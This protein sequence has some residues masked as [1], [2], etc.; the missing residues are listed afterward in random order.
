MEHTLGH[1]AGDGTHLNNESIAEP[2][3]SPP[4]KPRW[5]VFANTAFTVILVASAV[6]TVGDAMFD[7]GSSWLMTSLNPDPLMVSA[8]QIA[9]TLPMFLLTLPA[10]AISD[11]V[12]LRKLL[13]V[14]QVFV[15]IVAFGFAAA[16]WLNWHTPALLLTVTFLL[17]AGGA[18]AAPAWQLI[19]PMI[20]PRREL[21]NAIAV[22][23]ASYNLSRAIGPAIG[24]L[25]IGAFGIDFPFWINALS[26][27]AIVA[28]LV[29]WRP[30]PREVDT[31]PA[32]RL[33]NAVRTGLRYAANNR[34]L[35]STLIRAIVF[36]PFACSYSAL[37]PLIARTQMHS[38]PEVF[39][40]LMGVIGL[41]SIAASF[42]LRKL[43]ERL[44]PDSIAAAGT[45]GMVVALVLF[46]AAREPFVAV[47]ASFIA[48]ASS[49]IVMIT[50]FMSAQ[51][52]LPDW[53]RGRG[54]AVFL[55]VYFGAVTLGSAVWGKLASLE[56]IPAALYVSAGGALLGMVVTWRWKLQTGAAHD[57]A[58]SLHW[59]KPS[60]VYRA[61]NDQGPVLVTV[62]YLIDTKDREPFL[63]LMQEI[64]SQ[65]KRD[66][67]YAW[68]VFEDPTTAGRIVETCLLQSMLEYEY[69]R[70]RVTNADRLIEEQ[71]HRFQKEPQKVSFLVAAKRIRRPWRKL[72]SPRGAEITESE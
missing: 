67:V 38:G 52:A 30:P 25:S 17:G 28:A 2:N 34:D 29:W 6:S 72:H 58:P 44:G 12:D 20:V 14:V 21:A 4:A 22:N 64:G 51:V 70:K 49:I 55:T 24:G 27:L 45:I 26:F 9:I 62:E 15:A 57:L 61:E 7:T 46:A 56:G 47:A 63:A 10:G 42:G 16:I 35:D 37:L 32:E 1:T 19:A 33:M 53:V 48:G 23:S 41:G 11:I 59:R 50:L 39:G 8:V 31:L 5:G 18:L 65:R 60:F 13:I 40:A 66:G 43:T 36:F 71:A 3:A 54:L 69:A 68:N